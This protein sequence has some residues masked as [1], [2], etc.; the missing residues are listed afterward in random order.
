MKVWIVTPVYRDVESFRILRDRVLDVLE[1]GGIAERS[2][3]RFVVFDDT[4]GQDPDIRE[5]APLP[6]IRVLRPPFSL[7]HQ[8]GLVYALRRI[9]RDVGDD[10]LIVTLDADGE[11]RPE[12]L[13]RLL[14][15]LLAA[16]PPDRRIAL[17]LRTKRRESRAFKVMYLAFRGMFR[18]LTG[19]TVRTGNFVSMHG[20]LAKR[21]LLHPA[22]DLSYSSTILALDLPVVYV[23]CERGSRYRGRSKMTLGRLVAHG[24]RML[25]PFSDRIAVRALIVFAGALAVGLA[26]AL[27]VLGIKLFTDEAIPGWATFTALGAVILSVVALG[28]LVTLFVLFS[29]T[30][31]VSLSNL[32]ENDGDA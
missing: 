20:E 12:D 19:T 30:R 21:V 32:E 31:A 3:V 2:N 10:D 7:G 16:P 23:P 1:E 8:R 27:A 18:L 4:A 29:Q 14:A 6:D 5:L 11:D 28:N 17:A 24:A 26:L 15:P 9:L 13:P 25:M 22:F